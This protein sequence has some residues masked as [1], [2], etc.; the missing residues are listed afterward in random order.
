MTMRKLSAA[1][2]VLA[3]EYRGLTQEELGRK[4]GVTQAV[5]AKIEGGIKTEVP[6]ILFDD[7][8]DV[9]DFP[10]EFFQQEEDLIGF[11]SSAYYYR[12]KQDLTASDR[13]RIHGMVNLIRIQLKRLLSF[14]D[15]SG[16]FQSSTSRNTVEIRQKWLMLFAYFGICRTAQ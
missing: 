8:C 14:V 5:I 1:M 6:E 12:K 15:I 3:R 4:L 16:N 10:A 2:V 7:L 11:G 9:L 13:K